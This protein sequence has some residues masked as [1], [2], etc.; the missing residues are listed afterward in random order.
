M[1]VRTLLL[2]ILIAPL[3]AIHCMLA[4]MS[5]ASGDVYAQAGAEIIYFGARDDY[6]LLGLGQ[7]LEDSNEINQQFRLNVLTPDNFRPLKNPAPEA[8][9]AA[10]DAESIRLLSYFNPDIPIFNLAEENPL[11]RELCLPNV[12]HII[13]S[14]ALRAQALQIREEKNPGD[15]DVEALAWHGNYGY[16]KAGDLNALFL[17]K[18]KAKMVEQAWA[19]WIAARIF[20][21]A[22][23]KLTSAGKRNIVAFIRHQ[24]EIDGYKRSLVSF[25]SSG[26]LRQDLLIVSDEQVLAEFSEL[27][28]YVD[29][30]R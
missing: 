5:A 22:K 17:R 18:R 1:T 10:V 8:I 7:G 3:I 21:D 9:F 15:K 2:N 6:A 24:T 28:A 16:G 19:G 13:P 14:A 26:E 23:A 27:D 4:V 12:F 30:P 25:H 29:C 11:L 20:S